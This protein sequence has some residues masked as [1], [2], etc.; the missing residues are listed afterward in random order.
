M[1]KSLTFQVLKVEYLVD[2]YT[3]SVWK[4][5]IVSPPVVL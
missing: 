5:Y 3:Q 4:L 1:Q 2:M